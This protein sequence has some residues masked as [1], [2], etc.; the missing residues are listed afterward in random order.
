MP[1]SICAA[2]PAVASANTGRDVHFGPPITSLRALGIERDDDLWECPACGALF[3]WHDDS[4]FTGSGNNDEEVLT[5]LPREVA[6]VV[7]SVIHRGETR[8]ED[9]DV[10]AL[11]ALPELPRALV[12]AWTRAHDRA[13]ARRLVPAMLDV[14]E[15]AKDERSARWA[16]AF[17]TNVGSAAGVVDEL[18]RRPRVAALDGLR[19]H[20]KRALCTVCPAKAPEALLRIEGSETLDAWE[21]PACEAMFIGETKDGALSLYRLLEPA[22]DALR[23]CLRR[24]GVVSDFAREMVFASDGHRATKIVLA[25]AAKRDRALVHEFLPTIIMRLAVYRPE[26]LRDFMIDFVR[27]QSDAAA[28]LE[29]IAKCAKTGP[30]VDALAAHCRAQAP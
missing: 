26:W 6:E 19:R 10:P 29:A 2:I 5:R 18:A 16:H 24:T 17:V 28:V 21:C 13:L 14:V 11:L 1:C 27:E 8:V 30:M 22:S 23:A 7:R 3:H 25:H 4:A 12:L 20:F 9:V 15:A